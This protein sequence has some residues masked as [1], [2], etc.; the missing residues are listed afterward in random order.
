MNAAH[1]HIILNHIPVIGMIIGFFLLIIGLFAR[2]DLFVKASL[3][4]F[5][6]FALF[7]IPVF[8]T[9]QPAAQQISGQ[10]GFSGNAAHEHEELGEYSL[11]G[12]I[13]LA[14]ITIITLIV[15]WIRYRKPGGLI[16]IVVV[17]AFLVSGLLG[18]TAHK[19]GQVRRPELRKPE[20]PQTYREEPQNR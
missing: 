4:M 8:L 7:S 15:W 5:V 18:W 3:V 9:G 13:V 14:A 10:P 2:R 17:I 16:I 12:A 6:A 19:G 20:V 11:I 1:A